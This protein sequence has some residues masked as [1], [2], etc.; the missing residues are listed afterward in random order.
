MSGLHWAMQIKQV[1]KS[2]SLN[3]TWTNSLGSHMCTAKII[4]DISLL[5][6]NKSGRISKSA[7]PKE[8]M[9]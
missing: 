2:P 1:S 8:L 3:F 4:K 9:S 5:K 7:H 6:Q